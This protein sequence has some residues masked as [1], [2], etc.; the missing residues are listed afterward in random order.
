M[1]SIELTLIELD[2]VSRRLQPKLRLGSSSALVEDGQTLTPP[3][4]LTHAIRTAHP[5]IQIQ[6]WGL[7]F[8]STSMAVP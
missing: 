4:C 2:S 1:K 5:R 8:T 6:R 3:T 7:R